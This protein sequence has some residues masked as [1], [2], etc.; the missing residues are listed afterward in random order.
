M[1]LRFARIHLDYSGL[2]TVNPPL[3]LP[4]L[5]VHE[6]KCL[7][8]KSNVTRSVVLF[9][10][11]SFLFSWPFFFC[12]DVW[13]EPMFSAQGNP[14]AAQ[15]SRLF[16]H[17]LGM[18][19]PAVA[20][21]IMWRLY[22]RESPPPWKWSLPKYYGWIV[23]AMLAF[24]A[25]PGVIGLFFGDTVV[26]PIPTFIWIS[27][28]SMLVLGWI[29]GMGEETGWCA[30]LLPRMSPT[31]GKTGAVVLSGVIRGLWHWPIVVSPVILQVIA[32]EHTPAELVGAGIVIALQLVISNILFGVVFGWIWYRTESLPLVGWL[33]YWYD[34]ARDVTIMLL[35]GYGSSLWV[36]D[37]TAILF[38]MAGWLLLNDVLASDGLDWKKVFARLKRPKSDGAA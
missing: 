30:Y 27:I 33:H 1:P 26:S 3:K 25:L 8:Q 10:L 29:T 17:M 20:A 16:G 38:L 15:L 23:L 32:G 6:R 5:S 12:G 2:K 24:W 28:A 18:L 36:T 9:A 14:A 37:L 21:L 35:I 22:H 7:M 13:L 31:A 19:G 11:L 4:N 34:L